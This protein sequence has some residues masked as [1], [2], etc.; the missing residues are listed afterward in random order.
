MHRLRSSLVLL[1]LLWIPAMPVWSQERVVQAENVRLDYAQVLGVEPVYQTLRASRTEQ[2]CDEVPMPRPPETTPEEESRW[3]KMLDSVRSVFTRDEPEPPA[4][5]VAA[6]PTMKINCRLVPVER[7][8]Q[9]PIAYD[10][11]YI[12]KGV[13]YRSRLAEDPGNRLRIRVSVM[14][15]VAPSQQAASNP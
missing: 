3:S 8:F 5:A 4:K 6:A 10:V 11:D 1:V 9:R 2:K 15:Y 14:P 13:K 7:E 12:Y